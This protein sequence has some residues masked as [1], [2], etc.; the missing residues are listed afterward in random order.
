M[1]LSAS[2]NLVFKVLGV[3]GIL[4]TV[5]EPVKLNIVINIQYTHGLVIIE[6]KYNIICILRTP[7]SFLNS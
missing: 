4:A 2:S 5:F 1:G 7:K 3:I 6:D